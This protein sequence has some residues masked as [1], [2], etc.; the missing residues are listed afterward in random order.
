MINFETGKTEDIAK[1]FASYEQANK[2]SLMILFPDYQGK[3]F[4]SHIT[5]YD[6]HLTIVKDDDKGIIGYSIAVAMKDRG[7]IPHAFLNRGLPK[8]IYMNMVSKSIAWIRDNVSRTCPV[9]FNTDKYTD[10][11]ALLSL[12][13][14]KVSTVMKLR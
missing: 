12:R 7:V 10:V 5:K 14:V 1:A 13:F 2:D 3:E 9:L 6:H 11:P 4:L 8:R